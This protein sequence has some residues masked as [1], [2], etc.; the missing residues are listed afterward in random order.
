MSDRIQSAQVAAF[1]RPLDLLNLLLACTNRPFVYPTTQFR[2]PTGPIAKHWFFYHK[3]RKLL[4]YLF[5][6]D[7]IFD[8]P[9][10]WDTEEAFSLEPST[11]QDPNDNVVLDLLQAKSEAFMQTWQSLSED[12]SHH[13]TVDILQTLSSFCIVIALY[14]ECLPQQLSS[15]LQDLRRNSQHLWNGICS[16]LAVREAHF[17]HACLELLCPILSPTVC[18]SGSTSVFSKG[19]YDIISPFVEI[20]EQC[21]RTQKGYFSSEAGELMDLDDP[22]LAPNERLA[23][24]KSIFSSNREAL[25]L[26]PDFISLQRCMTIQLSIFQNLADINHSGQPADAALTEYLTELDDTDILSAQSVLSHIYRACS[27]MGRDNLLQILEDLAEKC[28]QSY[29]LERCESSLCLCIHMMSSFVD[30]WTGRENDDLSDSASDIYTWFMDVL[31]ARRKASSGVYI[32]LGELLERVLISNAAYSSDD[33]NPSPRTSLFTILQEGDISVKFSAANLIPRLFGRFL[34]KDHDAIFGDVLD[35]LPRDPDWKEGIAL[36]LLVLAQLASQW[37]TLLRRSIYHM[38]ETAAQV[39]DSVRYAEK[40]LRNVSEVLGLED[41]RELFRLFSSQILYTWTEAHTIKSMP[42]GVFGYAT[43]EEMLIDVQDEVVG[44]IVMRAKDHEAVQLAHYV[45][46]PF[47]ELLAASFYKAVAYGIARDTSIPPKQESRGRGVE[48]RLRKLLGADQFILLTETH[49]PQAIATF[50]Q[51]LDQH[52]QIERAFS[53]RANFRYA[54][55]IMK[56][57]TGKSA[58][59]TTLP[60]N[61]Q[62]SFRARYLLDEL[63][64]FCKRTGY[65]LETIWTPTLAS[66]V[67]RTLLE[68]IHPALGSLHACSV[69]RKI[70]ILVC[71]AGPVMLRDYPFEMVLHALRPFLTDLHCSEDALGIFWYLLEAGAPYLIENPRFMA[72]IAVSTFV[73]LKN[74]F[75]S[76]PE[77]TTQ[78][79]QFRLV[80]ENARRFHQ[81]LGEF[82]ETYQP[83]TMNADPEKNAKI[84]ESFGR[85]VRSSQKISAAGNAIKGTNES[86]LLLEILKDRNSRHNLL[87][88]PISDLV[89]SLLCVDFRRPL[90]YRSDIIMEDEDAIDNSVAV[91]ETLQNFDA[92]TEYRL[93]AARAIGRAFTA[94]GKISEVLLREQD[95]SLLKV[96]D[97]K[98]VS[99]FIYKSKARILQVLCNMLQNSSYLE[100]GLVERTLQLIITNIDSAVEFE[101]YPRVIPDTLMKALIWNPY[102]CPA[103]SLSASVTRR[104]ENI[105]GWDSKLAFADWACS[106]A[107][108]LSKAAPKDPVVGPLSKILNVIPGLAVQLLPYILH[109]VLADFEERRDTRR[110]ISEIF[111]QALREVDENTIPHARLVI[112]CI[113]YLRNQPRPGESTIAERNDWLDIDYEEASFAANKCRMHKTSLLFLEIQASRVIAGSRRSSL[114]KYDPPS[115]FLHDVFKNID[116]PDFYYGIQEKPSLASVMERLD[117]EST[118]IKNL[119]FHSAQYDSEMQMSGNANAYGVLKALNATNLQGIASAMFSAPS[120]S[121]DGPVSFDSMLQAATSLQQW[122]IPVS[123]MNISPSAIVF[124][125]FQNINTSGN[126]AE[127]SPSIDESFLSILNLLASTSRSALSLR[128]A[129][130]ALGIMTEISDVLCSTSAQ[131]IDEEWKKITYRKTLLQTER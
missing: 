102:Q 86:D 47:E 119:L 105:V 127:I 13:I 49:F 40:C 21:R 106:I 91:W 7:G 109:D 66:F 80:L 38:F 26:F 36:R 31:L 17:I 43:V 95:P 103:I 24:Q 61:Q 35:S 23:A 33:S 68:S 81:W 4:K 25:P 130:R 124:R 18:F 34:L 112:N 98:S 72:G 111:K 58:S 32:A 82:L 63:E 15:R 96:H 62:P 78:E 52:E 22:L 42:F 1:A 79:A 73:S 45:H 125:V 77:K 88:R 56:W 41:A 85:L 120:D 117:Y 54:L 9:N 107:L 131:Q 11:R 89:L 87:S 69:I 30:S 74:F 10:P 128:T 60:A 108:F 126:I 6:V 65:E 99:G 3:N 122:D 14:A 2:G 70:R 53:K 93:W 118:G 16:Y 83:Q 101:D 8:C 92:G 44:Q 94:T 12:K 90:D 71:V 57:I 75:A 115:D 110:T 51:S 104:G 67:C 113:L 84:N 100:V 123:P 27:G 55:D 37:H 29:E 5:Q 121:K 64:F 116:D 129:M 97:S 48:G 59:K 19:L 50:F 114:A 76:S 39:P 28:L 20:L 46:I